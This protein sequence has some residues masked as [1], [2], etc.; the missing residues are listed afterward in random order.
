[1]VSEVFVIREKTGSRTE[2][3]NAFAEGRSRRESEIE[4]GRRKEEG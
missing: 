1:M 4:G 3:K 2:T